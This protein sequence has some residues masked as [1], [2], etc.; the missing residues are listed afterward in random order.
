[1]SQKITYPFPA[2]REGVFKALIQQI[3]AGGG[4]LI[5]PTETFYALGGSARDETV[6]AKIFRLKGRRRNVPFPLLIDSP[7]RLTDLAASVPPA[8]AALTAKFW[9]GPLTLVFT[10]R[11]GLPAGTVSTE[12]KV[13]LRVSSHPLL[14]ELAAELTVPLIATSANRHGEPAAADLEE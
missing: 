12:G 6:V 9:P 8:A 11:P 5:F 13:A 7:E 4:T 14:R 2:G 10:A 3:I 1:M